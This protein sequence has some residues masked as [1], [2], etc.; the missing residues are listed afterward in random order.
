[1]SAAHLHA[2]PDPD[3]GEGLEAPLV[4]GDEGA[5]AETE[6]EVGLL[7]A[8]F[9][10]VCGPARWLTDRAGWKAPW[11]VHGITL[12]AAIHYGGWAAVVIAVAWATAVA[13]FIPREYL[14]RVARR[15]EQR[16]AP[17]HA[18]PADDQRPAATPEEVYAATLDWI[19]NQIADS[20]GVHLSD[21]L[22]HAHAHGLHTDLDV[23]AFRAVLERWGIPV[24]QQLK[25]GGR[26]RPGIHRIDLPIRQPADH[27]PLK[28]AE[29]STSLDYPP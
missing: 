25:V 17:A 27:A 20:N 28:S 13:L 21:L 9:T 16:G 14:E 7:C 11:V 5:E 8:L 29:P 26:N 15:I 22:A 24:R 10:G 19:R 6:E 1:M 2:V 23:G 3:D 4:D 12:Y 18:E